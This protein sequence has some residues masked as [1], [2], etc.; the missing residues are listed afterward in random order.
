MCGTASCRLFGSVT[1]A[2]LISDHACDADAQ[3]TCIK[4]VIRVQVLESSLN[5]AFPPQLQIGNG[6]IG[7]A[8]LEN[9]NLNVD[10][11]DT[12]IPPA[13]LADMQIRQFIHSVFQGR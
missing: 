11:G 6:W 10:H 7:Q 4:Y 5:R 13:Y 12:L 9:V 2:S 8:I 3:N 1:R